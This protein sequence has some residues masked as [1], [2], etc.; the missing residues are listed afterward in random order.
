MPSFTIQ[1]ATAENVR[2][3][4]DLIFSVY[5]YTYESPWM[6]E[7][8]KIMEAVDAGR[9]I[10]FLAVNSAGKPKGCLGL[11]FPFGARAIGYFTTLAI[12][13]DVRG[14][15]SGFIFRD[16]TREVTRTASELSVKAGLRVIMS[17]EV[18]L[19]HLS[20]R[21]ILR[22]G[23]VNCGI[24]LAWCPPWSDRTR[25]FQSV[26]SAQRAGCVPQRQAY[27]ERR[28]EVISI[29]AFV[30]KIPAA[31]VC[32]PARYAG[33]LRE[34]YRAARLPATFV[35]GRRPDGPA[36]VEERLD[37]VR[38]L[39]VI[40]VTRVGADT[41]AVIA[42][43]MNRM[44]DGMLDLIHVYLPLTQGDIS[45]QVEAL[46]Q[47]GFSYCT[48]IPV[49]R[50]GDVLVMQYLNGIESTLTEAQLFSPLAK[51]IFRRMQAGDSM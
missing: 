1:R 33:L 10:F 5:G 11:G 28:A 14:V 29:R 22:Y 8:S 48:V 19:H 24:F 35:G 40:D 39:G 16:L 42:G 32:L 27:Y 50:S 31:Q 41:I 45:E 30:S 34:V 26:G 15:E 20:Q 3:I 2:H 46:A 36:E 37:Y 23:F 51:T 9:V 17:T 12:A 25:D 43:K 7:P 6:Y 4:P 47:Q 49:Y 18:T 13:P 21:L 44:R 38:S